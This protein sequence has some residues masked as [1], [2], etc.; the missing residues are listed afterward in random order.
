MPRTIIM[1]SD[2]WRCKEEF[3]DRLDLPVFYMG[4]FSLLGIVVSDFPGACH[5]LRNSGYK[6]LDKSG[7][8][9]IFFDGPEHLPPM[10]QALQTAA[11]DAELRDI[12]EALYQA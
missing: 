10:L 9:D 6:V 11:I 1:L 7:V 4:D 8:A 2:S 3:V 5:A 12:A